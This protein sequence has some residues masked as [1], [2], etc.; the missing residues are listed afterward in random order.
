MGSR[1]N[2]ISMRQT[3]IMYIVACLSPATRLFPSMGARYGRHAGWAGVLV[4][5]AA[6][7]ALAHILAAL[8]KK[9]DGAPRGLADVFGSVFG[10]IGGKLITAAYLLWAVLLYA[11]YIRYYAERMLAT[12]FTTADI[13][14]F[15]LAMMPLVFIAARGRLEVFARFS[16]VSIL[17]FTVI[18]LALAMCLMPTFKTENVWPVTHLDAV[19]ILK[20]SYP[21][22][23]ILGYLTLFFFLGEHISNKRDAARQ[24]RKAAVYIGV[25]LT[26]I[27]AICIGTLSWRVVERMPAPFFSTTKLITVMQP[28]DRL[29]ALLLSEWVISDFIIITALAFIVMNIAK[30]FF[31]LKEER[32]LAAPV[33]FFGFVGGIYVAA[34]RFALEAFSNSAAALAVNVAMGFGVPALTLL[35]G[36]IRRVV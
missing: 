5:A 28:L 27:T 3:M 7:A 30:K 8:F 35:A 4:G 21:V 33:V 14:F 25:M 23:G 12:I 17:L 1:N 22:L 2:K 19:P 20:S 11:L 36:K 13:R 16:E 29:E 9:D 15:M 34:D 6:L 24:G 26:L 18:L 31:N 10:R 32:R